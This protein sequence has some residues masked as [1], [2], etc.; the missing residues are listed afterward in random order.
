[1]SYLFMGGVTEISGHA[2][3][4]IATGTGYTLG[5]GMTNK[6]WILYCA[7]WQ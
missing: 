4:G 2:H 7:K 1:M 5:N 6:V 3:V